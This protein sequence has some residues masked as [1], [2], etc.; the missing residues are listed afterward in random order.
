MKFN[1]TIESDDAAFSGQCSTRQE[2]GRLLRS[3][4]EKINQRE[5]EGALMDFQ[6]NRCGSWKLEHT[7]A[8][9]SQPLADAQSDIAEALNVLQEIDRRADLSDEQAT[10]V[11]ELVESTDELYVALADAYRD[12]ER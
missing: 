10:T 7:A 5:E 12:E 6:G 3:V 9:I 1:L 4:A 8:D 11:R 2:L